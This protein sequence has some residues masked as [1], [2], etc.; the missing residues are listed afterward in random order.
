MKYLMYVVL[1]AALAVPVLGNP[2]K[3][4]M[5]YDPLQFE[6]GGPFFARVVQ[7]SIAGYETG[8]QFL[9]FCVE[10]NEYFD[11][12]SKQYYAELNTAAVAGGAGGAVDGKDELDPRTAYLFDLYLDGQLEGLAGSGGGI[13]TKHEAGMVQNAIWMLEDEITKDDSN[14]YYALVRDMTDLDGIGQIRIMNL[15]TS[16]SYDNENNPIYSGH[17][18]D[19]L[20]RVIPAPGALLLGSLGMG[21]VSWMRRR[22]AV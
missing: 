11:P 9:T 18:Q 19:Q 7:G 15:W 2:A 17:V 5:G 16:V 20:V 22:Q 8:E 21:L 1:L 14:P 3:V 6:E 12:Y 10:Y 13:D 4:V